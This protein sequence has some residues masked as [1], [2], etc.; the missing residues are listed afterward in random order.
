MK[1]YRFYAELPD[2]RASKSASKRYAAFT[3]A[4]LEQLA[5]RGAHNNCVAVPLDEA[6]RPLW[7]GATMNAD[8]VVSVRGTPN[9]PVCGGSV[10]RDYLRT[11]CVRVPQALACQL[12]PNL[13]T[14][15]DA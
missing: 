6:G 2:G 12:H 9:S 1:G 11:R 14:Y 7:Q 10:S 15:L 4:N 5:A 8:A 3:R 13:F